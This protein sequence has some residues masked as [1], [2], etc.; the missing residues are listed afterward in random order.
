M[1]IDLS[2][3]LKNDRILSIEPDITIVISGV[4][5]T[6]NQLSI[7]KLRILKQKNLYVMLC[8]KKRPNDSEIILDLKTK[9]M[10]PMLI[11]RFKSPHFASLEFDLIESFIK[12]K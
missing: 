1:K 7:Q 8:F 3:C 11:N 4:G 5:K 6:E 2:Q 12:C 10:D 9:N